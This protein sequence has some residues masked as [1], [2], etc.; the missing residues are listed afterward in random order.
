METI[1][2]DLRYAIRTLAR[3]R[4]VAIVA[5][6]T[7]SI[8]I[9]A[10]T[11]MFSVVD[12]ALLRPPPF[13]EPDQLVM[14]YVTRTTPRD[15]LKFMRNPFATQWS[16]A[17]NFETTMFYVQ[18]KWDI[19]DALTM[20]GG[21]KSLKVDFSVA[22]NVNNFVVPVPNSNAD[23]HGTITAKDN[24]L[25]QVGVNYKIA[26]GNE[27]F[28]GYTENMRAWTLAPAASNQRAHCAAP[29]PISST[30]RSRTSPSNPASASDRPSGHQ[31]KRA[32][33]RNALPP[34]CMRSQ[35]AP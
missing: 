28:A 22:T 12:A 23:V 27:V 29:H 17:Y 14:L 21:F 7:L 18:D 2:Q 15:S 32:S 30:R 8:G 25:P 34:S 4:G 6:I 10:T 13:A 11:T 5:I 19:T 9:A 24:F 20:S 1:L 31:T 35:V 16:F 26:P 33:P 3:M